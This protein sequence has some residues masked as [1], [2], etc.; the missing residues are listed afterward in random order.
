M[1]KTFQIQ[2]LLHCQLQLSLLALHVTFWQAIF[3]FMLL[4]G[5]TIISYEDFSHWAQTQTKVALC[6]FLWIPKGLNISH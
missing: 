3:W 4:K 5:V 2:I 6:K 1:V